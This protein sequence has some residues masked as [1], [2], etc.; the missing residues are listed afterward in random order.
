MNNNLPTCPVHDLVIHPRENDL[1]VGTHGRGV[2]ITDVSP[3]QELTQDVLSK[4][5]F[6]FE[7]EPKVQWIM[8]HQ[9][10]VSYQ[11][12]EGKNEEHGVV[13][14]YFLKDKARDRVKISIFDGKRKINE[15]ICPNSRGINSVRWY[16]TKRVKRSKE[17][18][19]QWERQQERIKNEV[20]F[21][22]QY[23][24]VDYYGEADEEV[25]IWG[26]SLQ[27]YVLR[28]PYITEREYAAIRVKPGEYTVVLSAGDSKLARSA[29][30][31]KDYWYK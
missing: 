7:I 9:T 23:D 4:N 13:V 29:K 12:F 31:L 1:V 22:C 26:R 5:V 2:F 25:D 24:E 18:I 15:I 11:N 27:T 8:P 16:M 14:N 19:A 3:L 28:R 20:D 21:Y 10:V 6:L 17:E 30:I